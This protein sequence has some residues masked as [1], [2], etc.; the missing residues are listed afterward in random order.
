MKKRHFIQILFLFY[1]GIS[2]QSLSGQVSNFD[3]YGME[4]GLGQA[5]VKSIL[6]DKEG[7]MWFGTMAGVSRF[8]G[9][10]FYNFDTKDGL[11]S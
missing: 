8:D 10:K 6:Q 1:T 11:A 7:N 3:F 5:I 2:S 4:D 9:Q